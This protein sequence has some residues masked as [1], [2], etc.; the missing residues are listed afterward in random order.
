MLR[1][2]VAPAFLA[3]L[4]LFAPLPLFATQ[5]FMALGDITLASATVALATSLLP[6]GM[7]LTIWLAKGRWRASRITMLHGLAAVFVLQWC[8]V[9]VANE[10]LP[11]RLWA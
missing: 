7:L 9:L 6:V 10:M 3:S 1:R 2:P 5:S 8:A 4:L 11:F